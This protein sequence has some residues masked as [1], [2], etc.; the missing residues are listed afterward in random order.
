MAIYYIALAFD[1]NLFPAK[2]KHMKV[3]NQQNKM[4]TNLNWQAGQPETIGFGE[5]INN[6]QKTSKKTKC[7]TRSKQHKKKTMSTVI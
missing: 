3:E 4:S 2:N 1:I 5:G 7:H 6:K